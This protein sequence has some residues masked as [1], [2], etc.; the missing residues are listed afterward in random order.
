MAEI[1]VEGINLGVTEKPYDFKDES[2]ERRTGVS[3]RLHILVGTE[4]L[5]VRVPDEGLATARAIPLK[6]NCAVVVNLPR[7]VRVALVDVH[8][9][10]KAS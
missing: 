7:N 3:N 1:L 2:G 5:D 4:V 9:Q 10:P 6:G 8:V